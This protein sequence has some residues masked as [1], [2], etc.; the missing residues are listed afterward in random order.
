MGDR[1]EVALDHL[2]ARAAERDRD[3]EL[4]ILQKAL[5][6]EIQTSNFYKEIVGQ[7]EAEEQ[8]LFARFIEIEEGH[9]AMVQA[10]ID[11]VSGTGFWFDCFEMNLEAG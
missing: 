5:T 9:E 4:R 2:E 8:K 10:Q 11:L 3:E 6:M 1:S 7:L